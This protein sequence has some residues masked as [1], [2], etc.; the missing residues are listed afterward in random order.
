MALLPQDPQQQKKLLLG[1]LPVLLVFGYFYMMHGDRTARVDS[2][3]TRLERLES[4]NATAR[5]QAMRGGP[6]LEEQLQMYQRHIDRL[7]DLVPRSEEVTRLLNDITLRAH[8]NRVEV[9]QIVPGRK[10]HGEYYTLE[11]YDIAAIGGYHEIGRFLTAIGSL[12]R[13]VTPVE[14][15]ILPRQSSGR[16]QARPTSELQASFRIKTYVL[17]SPH[18]VEEISDASS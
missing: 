14:L 3:T 2:L 8:E 18:A 9:A 15:S 11:S 12:P 5:V 1:L 6:E 13:I 10:E 16:N 7:E 4:R 17:P